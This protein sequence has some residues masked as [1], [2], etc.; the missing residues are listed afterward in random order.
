ML[1]DYRTAKEDFLRASA[2]VEGHTDS[3]ATLTQDVERL[4]LRLAELERAL[5][6]LR[7]GVGAPELVRGLLQ[8]MARIIMGAIS[9]T[10]VSA[11]GVFAYD[12]AGRA[13]GADTL[14]E[15]RIVPQDLADPEREE[16][17]WPLS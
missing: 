16:P 14:V 6:D 9:P 5:T 1:D 2:L 10:S 7:K 17:D 13:A 15:E 3:I 4:K 8:E 11:P 12:G